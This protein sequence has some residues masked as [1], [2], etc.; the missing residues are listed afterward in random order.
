[1]AEKHDTSGAAPERARD[2]APPV[3]EQG[4][5]ERRS[6]FS[7]RTRRRT[8]SGD[9]L[10]EQAERLA[11]GMARRF[12]RLALKDWDAV[13]HAAVTEV[14][15]FTDFTDVTDVTGLLGAP[16]DLRLRCALFAAAIDADRELWTWET[17]L[18]AE[19]LAARIEAARA[20]IPSLPSQRR[21]LFLGMWLLEATFHGDGQTSAIDVLG[22]AH[23]MHGAA[24]RQHLSRGW[25]LVWGEDREGPF[26]RCDALRFVLPTPTLEA[27]RVA[28]A[29][30]DTVLH[31]PRLATL[32]ERLNRHARLNGRVIAQHRRVARVWARFTEAL[33]AS[34]RRPGDVSTLLHAR[35]VA[36]HIDNRLVMN[37][38][39]R[40]T[41]TELLSRS[42]RSAATALPRW[43]E[44]VRD[45]AFG[46]GVDVAFASVE[47]AVASLQQ[48][49][50]E[51][52]EAWEALCSLS[53]Q[54]DDFLRVKD[55]F[56]SLVQGL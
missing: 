27:W 56:R 35:S 52:D 37:K 1:M 34:P 38:L 21:E 4:D 26:A 45:Q 3:S 30:V 24:V 46:P 16:E 14:T 2:S 15:R 32:K 55:E 29:F 20:S 5:A 40:L 33:D 50:V 41:W 36:L 17:R 43:R 47:E 48:H 10:R 42:S 51:L 23:A 49:Q 54:M 7:T 31:D 44:L 19:P 28:S 6:G 13:V 11:F 25:Q 53:E 9:E 39:A 18:E 8:S 12:P 22:V